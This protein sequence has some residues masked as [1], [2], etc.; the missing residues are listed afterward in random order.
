MNRSISYK[1]IAG[2]IDTG[3]KK[4]SKFTSYLGL[5]L[6]VLLLL[7]AVQ[8]FININQLIKDKN[9]RKNGYDYI[10]ITK[11]ITNQNMGQDNRF[12]T[13]DV[14]EL[15]KQPFIT[16]AAPLISNQFRVKA[17]AGNI[18]P[19]STDLFLEAIQNDFIDTLPPNFT[20]Q[21]GQVTVPII[22]SADYLEMYNVFAPAQDLPQMSAATISTVN[23][24]LEC[25]APYG[26]QTFKGNIVAIS[27]R[28]NSVLVPENFLTWANKHY[29]NA[30]NVPAARVFI[31][32]TDANSSELLNFLQEKDYRI[33]KDK[34]K[35]GRVKQVLQAIVT[36]LGSF[37]VLVIILA[38]LLFSFYLQ[39][40]I[41]RSKDNLQL[42]ITLGYSPG[43]LSKTVSYKWIPV[44]GIIIAVALLVTQLIQ[45]FFRHSFLS[46][47]ETLSPMLNWSVVGLAVCLFVLCITINYRLI[48]KLLYHL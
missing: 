18:I 45:F 22:F 27:D 12:T 42:L 3:G 46:A 48:K 19:F 4:R 6:G 32:T 9:P 28:I 35:F 5:C 1:T 36:G 39:L 40:M 25:Y 15:K 43:W 20:W 24:N 13:A 30:E 16:D 29:G 41:A 34:T 37:A 33:N 26:F 21:Q 31:K 23:I 38:M 14:A 47:R 8:M 11:N 10:S 2:L 44:Y 7:V 17:S